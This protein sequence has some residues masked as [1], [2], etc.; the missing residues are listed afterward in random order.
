MFKVETPSCRDFR[1]KEKKYKSNYHRTLKIKLIHMMKFLKLMIVLL[2]SSAAL[3]QQIPAPKEHFGFNI[4][5]N[6]KLA[7]YAQT[8]A[9][10]QKL[11]LVSDRAIMQS[12]GKT[13]EGRDQFMMVVTLI[14]QRDIPKTGKS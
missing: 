12:I 8:E 2:V 11:D 14:L 7:T 9:Y 1:I 5:D 6:Y 3:G 4:G 10:F 13:E